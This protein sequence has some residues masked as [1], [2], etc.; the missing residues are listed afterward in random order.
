[1]GNSG[2]R[3]KTYF[4]SGQTACPTRLAY[5]LSPSFNWKKA[6]PRNEQETYIKRLGELA[7][8]GG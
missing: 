1:M 6:M 2:C 8:S 5:N 4:C 3:E 7:T